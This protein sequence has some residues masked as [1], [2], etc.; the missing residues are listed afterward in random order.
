M[1]M[2]ELGCCE[3]RLAFARHL[4]IVWVLL[5]YVEETAQ[6]I[7]VFLLCSACALK[8]HFVERN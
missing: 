7:V 1:S 4:N 3:V 8:L 2:S 5:Q 6:K